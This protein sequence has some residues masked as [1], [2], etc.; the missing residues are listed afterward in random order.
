MPRSRRGP[1]VETLNPWPGYVDALSTLLMVI[2][3]VLLVF[4]L[5]QAFLSVALS[6]RDKAVDRLQHEV[7]QISDALSLE[8]GRATELHAAVAQATRE[9]Q[10]STTERDS[11]TEQLSAL[12]AAQARMAPERDA[13]IHDRDT[14]AAQLADQQ[15]QAQAGIARTAELQAQLGAA[16]KQADAQGQDA[17]ATIAQLAEARRALLSAQADIDAMR[18]QA[19]ELDRTVQVDRAT[20]QARLSDLAH[21]TEQAQSLANLRDDLTRQVLAANARTA[22]T[23]TEL[24]VARKYGEALDQTVQADRATI[25]A[26]VSELA[27]L[28]EQARA[29][30]ALRDQLEA[31]AQ[32]AAVRVT[33]EADRRTAVA[34]Q[35]ADEQKLGDSTRA[36]LAQVA[37]DAEA[38]RRQLASVQQALQLSEASTQG[39]D[40][41]IA[42]LGSRLNAAL[43]QKVEELQ[44]YRSEF[45]GRLRQVLANRPG[46][47]VVGDRFVFQSEVLFPAGSAN[48][49]EGGDQQ[50][51]ALAAT[52][53]T[54]AKE[55][56]P[57]VHWVLRVDGHADRQPI[58]PDGG[59]ATNL[60]LSAARAIHVVEL[61]IAAGVPADR[62]AATAFGDTQPLDPA[63]TPDAYSKNR[64]I[65]IRLTDR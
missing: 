59:Y 43:A 56:P 30:A 51:R 52:L 26:R 49:S 53:K 22:A 61:L 6:G 34:A 15:A 7:A 45:F 9:L 12:A 50:V 19:I 36:K 8:R 58:N 27:R 3:F 35:L 54:I 55:I 17:A 41:Q 64:R 39:K 21:M 60:D 1:H 57:D 47:Q 33:S 16:A 28:A 13:L 37:Q 32:T 65:E 40:T 5:A 11:L 24:G 10:S 25:Q 14:L 63:N 38:L 44:G 29:L 48:M 31:Q 23:Q 4:V 2:I 20:M 42:N 62:L 46:V 18:K